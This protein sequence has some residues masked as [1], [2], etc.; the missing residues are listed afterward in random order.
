VGWGWPSTR[1]LSRLAAA[2]LVS[3]DEASQVHKR[4]QPRPCRPA[5]P[6]RRGAPMTTRGTGTTH[7]SQRRWLPRQGDRRLH[8]P[9]RYEAFCN[10]LTQVPGNSCVQLHLMC[11]I[12]GHT[13]WSRAISTSHCTLLHARHLAEGSRYSSPSRSARFLIGPGIY[14]GRCNDRSA[15]F[16]SRR[17]ISDPRQRKTPCQD[18]TK[19]QPNKP[20]GVGGRELTAT[21]CLFAHGLRVSRCSSETYS[22]TCL[23]IQPV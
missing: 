9:P 1:P 5:L 13:S 2:V 11:P 3:V 16:V 18:L 4:T 21:C 17:T 7:C 20:T 22:Y 23:L 19:P 15:L 8:V 10:F 6:G 12:T 14:H